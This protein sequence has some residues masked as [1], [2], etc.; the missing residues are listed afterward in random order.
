MK[1]LTRLVISLILGL[2]SVQAAEAH[3]PASAA[4]PPLDPN[5]RLGSVSF[6]VSCAVAVQPAFSRGVALLHDFWYD[7]A[8]PQFESI[9]KADPSC[10][11]AHWG[12][13]MSSF[14][15]I[16][17]RPDEMTL[18]T[19]W[20]QLEAARAHPAKTAREREYIAALR[21]FFRPGKR[22]YQVRVQAYADAMAG[23]YRHHPQDVDAGAFYALSLLAAESPDDTS[24]AQERTALEVLRPLFAHAPDNPGVVHYIIHACDTPSLAAEGLA[25][26][27]HYGAIAGSGP[28]AAHMPGHIYSRLGMWQADVDSQLASIAASHAA[29]ARHMSGSMDQFHSYDFLLYAYLQSGQDGHAKAVL[30]DSAGMLDHFDAMPKMGDSYMVGMFPYYRTKYPVF[31]SLEMR[32]WQA[33]AAL[34]PIKSAPPDTQLLT[35][36]ART[37]ADG[38]LHR[39]TRARA[40]LA[41][42]DALMEQV[43]QGPRAYLAGATG[44]RIRRAEMLGWVAFADGN[45]AEAAQHLRD[46]ADLQDEV[47]QGEVDIPA[48]EMLADVLLEANRPAEALAEYRVA[49]KFSPNRFNG[50]Y[51]AGRAAEAAGDSEQAIAYYASLLKSTHDGVD[52]ARSEIEHAKTFVSAARLAAQQDSY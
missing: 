16:W 39:A 52:S 26:A 18:A 8:Q 36:W 9:L 34:E 11:M 35:Y 38:H 43:K 13:A 30:T 23:L 15:Q 48:R 24:L 14:H 10:A 32:N 28:H 27:N 22:E 3:G 4:M 44:A 20:A 1:A 17:D 2:A 47:G 7:E 21:E 25:A 46:A 40:D 6:S 51:N 5:E 42:Y 49:L 31:Y 45:T 50:L 41:G 12:V 29:E 33:A 37:I 19:G